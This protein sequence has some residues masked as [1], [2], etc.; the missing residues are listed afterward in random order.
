M[1][2]LEIPNAPGTLRADALRELRVR[3]AQKE[4]NVV[5]LNRLVWRISK[6]E[7]CERRLP[8]LD[9]TYGGVNADVVLLLKAPQADADPG[10][11]SEQARGSSP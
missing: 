3:L 4:S 6:R 10:N 8:Y 5:E 11:H 2:G 9:P 1:N 7:N